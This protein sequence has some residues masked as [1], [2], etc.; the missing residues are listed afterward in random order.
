MEQCNDKLTSYFMYKTNEP[1][2]NKSSQVTKFLLPF[3]AR[4]AVT[5]SCLCKPN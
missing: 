5:F 2:G 3:A 4:R 1:Y